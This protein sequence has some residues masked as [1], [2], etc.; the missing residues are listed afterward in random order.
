MSTLAVLA[1]AR[2]LP[3]D[4]R[5]A[6]LAAETGGGAGVL[7]SG[8]GQAIEYGVY[9]H[10]RFPDM[11]NIVD[12]GFRR[13]GTARFAPIRAGFAAKDF[14]APASTIRRVTNRSGSGII[15]RA[16]VTASPDIRGETISRLGR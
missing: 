3:G 4:A 1:A 2:T 11:D 14:G 15:A 9:R 7:P 10:S 13:K 5:L 16:P 8:S 12:F 6:V